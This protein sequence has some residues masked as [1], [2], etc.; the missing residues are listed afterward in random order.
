MVL[1]GLFP[2]LRIKKMAKQIQVILVIF[3]IIW[4][5]GEALGWQIGDLPPQE[6]DEVKKNQKDVTYYGFKGVAPL[7][8]CKKDSWDKSCHHSGIFGCFGALW[9]PPMVRD[10]WCATLGQWWS[11]R[12]QKDVT[13]DS[14]KGLFPSLSTKKMA[15]LNLVIVMAFLFVLGLW[16][17]SPGMTD[18]W[19]ATQEGEGIG[20]IRHTLHLKV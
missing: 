11:R 5:P 20:W 17:G 2:S 19:C 1:R 8:T 6:G 16:W 14:F 7:F 9:G 3:L 15:D 12:N 18:G 4:L 13:F 10:G